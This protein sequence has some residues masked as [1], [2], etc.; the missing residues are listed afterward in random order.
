MVLPSSEV[1]P[2]EVV[3]V[4]IYP[5]DLVEIYPWDLVEISCQKETVSSL[6]LLLLL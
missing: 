5:W 3:P 2:S 4:R 6:L 1:I